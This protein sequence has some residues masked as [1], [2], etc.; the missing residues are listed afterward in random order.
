MKFHCHAII[1]FTVLCLLFFISCKKKETVQLEYLTFNV[2]EKINLRKLIFLNE[3]T[4]FCCGGK[5]NTYGAIFKTTDSGKNWEKKYMNENYSI[6]SIFFLNDS[7]GYACGDSLTLY[8]SRDSGNTWSKYTF[9]NLPWF[10][11]MIPFHSLYFFSEDKGFAVGGEHFGKGGITRTFNRGGEWNHPCFDN[12]LSC[13]VFPDENTGFAGGYGVIYKTADGGKS[14][15]PCSIRGDWFRS[16]FFF[17]RNKGFAAGYNGSLF[18]T[19]DAGESW[20]SVNKGNIA[21]DAREHFNDIVFSG[22]KT[23]FISCTNGWL[24]ITDDGGVSWKKRMKV[25]DDALNSSFVSG[26]KTLYL[27]SEAGNIYKLYIP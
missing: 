5:K 3:S 17:S 22:E 12:E 16:L 27:C 4:G 2:G 7:I 19:T 18:M 14:F 26:N 9:P 21:F 23:G 24:L 25:C 1:I 13:I 8:N 15:S 6:N 20:D 11:F 10:Q